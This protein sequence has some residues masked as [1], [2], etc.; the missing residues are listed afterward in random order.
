MRQ[1]YASATVRRYIKIRSCSCS[2]CSL[3]ETLLVPRTIIHRLAAVML[4]A[5]RPTSYK[6]THRAFWERT[7]QFIM[8]RRMEAAPYALDQGECGR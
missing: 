7:S 3:G 1:G 5:T 2:G 4:K 8:D 6:Q